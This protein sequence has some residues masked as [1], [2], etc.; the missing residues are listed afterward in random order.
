LTRSSYNYWVATNGMGTG[1]FTLRVT[2]VH[3]NVVE[4]AGIPLAPGVAFR[5]QAQF[6]ECAKD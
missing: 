5:G 3:G 6:P 1:P 4:Q 2:D